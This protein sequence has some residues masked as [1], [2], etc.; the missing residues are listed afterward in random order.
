MVT[1]AFPSSIAEAIARLEGEVATER[2]D[3]IVGCDDYNS[4]EDHLGL[5][6]YI[7]NEYGLWA[8]NAPLLAECGVAHPDSASHV[9]LRALWEHLRATVSDADLARA[10]A[11]RAAR[12][13]KTAR[14]RRDKDD[15][16]AAAW[17]RM[18][19]RRCPKCSRPC[20]EFRKTCAFCRHEVGRA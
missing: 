12:E 9:I 7:R 20:P 16:L 2:L 8:G 5:A 1:K 6:M 17:E 19:E 18:T 13:E 4:I 14:A 11:A 10:R 15:K 3:L